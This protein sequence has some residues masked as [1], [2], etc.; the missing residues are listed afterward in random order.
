MALQLPLH[1][2]AGLRRPS[3]RNTAANRLVLFTLNFVEAKEALVSQLFNR[4][5][6]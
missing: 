5:R 4:P 3:T 6:Q 2:F 1:A